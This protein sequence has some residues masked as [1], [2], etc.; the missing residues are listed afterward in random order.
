MA[1]KLMIGLIGLAV[2]LSVISSSALSS[3]RE[4]QELYKAAKAEGRVIWQYMGSVNEIK[5][6]TDAFQANYPEIKLTV[7][8]VSSASTPTRIIGEA[9]AKR[10]TLDV[11]S[12]RPANMIPLIERDLLVK[13][14]WT[15]IG[16]P[17]DA[18][19]LDGLCI[20]MF[21]NPHIWVRNTNL[22]SEAEQPKTWED[23]LLPKWKGH[24]IS[25]RA[26]A[27]AFAP[28]FFTWRKDKQKAIDYIER[29]KKQE[30]V[31]GKRTAEVIQRIAAGECPIGRSTMSYVLEAIKE[32]APIALMPI[33]PAADFGSTAFIPKG[34]PH[35]NAAKF[36]IAWLKGPEA[37]KEWAKLG[38]GLASPPEAS[39]VARTLAK[40]GVKFER[41]VSKEDTV[42]FEEEFAKMVVK[43]MG[44]LPE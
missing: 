24:K 21:E 1:K 18:I 11:A 7:F 22:V 12:S 32:K 5:G 4:I 9:M 41:I 39:L 3:E 34:V 6:V 33:S 17:K 30:V 23:A 13:Y 26:S 14:D 40:N 2:V 36:F 28:L 38:Y 31:P 16:V 20:N 25:I 37:E 8:S 19:L 44:F 35:P 29:F 15:K 42:E 10:F 27:I 43:I